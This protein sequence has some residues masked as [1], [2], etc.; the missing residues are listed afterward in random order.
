MAIVS[1]HRDG[2]QEGV[3]FEVLHYQ[4]TNLQVLILIELHPLLSSGICLQGRRDPRLDENEQPLPFLEKQ[5]RLIKDFN[6]QVLVDVE[7]LLNQS[8]NKFGLVLEISEEAN[9]YLRDN[10]DESLTRKPILKVISDR[11]N[12]GAGENITDSYIEEIFDPT[13]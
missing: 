4:A 7:S 12:Q 3:S 8:N 11:I 1:L 10:K 6:R 13:D 2:Q 9:D 5:E